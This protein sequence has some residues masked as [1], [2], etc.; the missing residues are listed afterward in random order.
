MGQIKIAD[1]IK[2]ETLT[3]P[4]IGSLHHAHCSGV[5]AFDD[6]E[7]LVE[8]KRFMVFENC[9]VN[10]GPNRFLS[11]KT[12]QI[13]WKGILLSGLL[14]IPRYYGCSMSL[15]LEAGL[16]SLQNIRLVKIEE[17]LGQNQRRFIGLFPEEPKI[18]PF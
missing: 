13:G 9:Q 3:K 5:V 18:R 11:V 7:L 8:S 2:I 4:V 12:N 6:G 10:S 14:L 1:G 17:K 16:W 15:H